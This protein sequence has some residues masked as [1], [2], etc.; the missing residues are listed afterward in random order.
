MFSLPNALAVS[1]Q[2]LPSVSS[3]VVGA[4]AKGWYD[5]EKAAAKASYWEQTA[6]CSAA[7][8]AIGEG[9]QKLGLDQLTGPLMVSVISSIIG[10]VVVAS[11]RTEHAATP[12]LKK[13]LK[14]SSNK[15]LV[16]G[17]VEKLQVPRYSAAVA[18][19]AEKFKDGLKRK[20]GQ[21][22]GKGTVE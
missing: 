22:R 4:L 20:G 21:G 2:W 19:A 16:H 18:R 14:M 6:S 17:A 9:Q 13:S 10:I 12:R 11:S 5:Q 1:E 15:S 3:A 8:N 7:G